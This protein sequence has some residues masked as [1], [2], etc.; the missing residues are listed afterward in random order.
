MDPNLIDLAKTVS[1]EAIK[2][3]GPA[4]VAAFTGYWAARL[5]F[6]SRLKE[7]ERS[8]EFNA[9]QHLFDYYKNRQA[10]LEEGHKALSEGL[11]RVLGVSAAAQLHGESGDFS[12]IVSAFTGMVDVYL[13]IVPFDI[14]LTRRDMKAK[15]LDAMEEF[16]RL[17]EYR[18]T[19]SKLKP[20]SGKGLEVIQAN[21]YIL[22][23]IYSFLVRCNQLLLEQQ[24]EGLFSKYM[25]IA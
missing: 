23:E 5:Q 21:V 13:G 25:K 8:H 18:E 6:V 16:Q 14:D 2:I 19:S 24:I 15:G 10:K 9:R 11:G 12:K 1:L 20:A 17:T 3:L 7:L 22:L 4:V